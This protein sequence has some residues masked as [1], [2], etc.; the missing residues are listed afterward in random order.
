MRINLKDW[1]S[2]RSLISSA[3]EALLTRYP[4]DPAIQLVLNGMYAQQLRIDQLVNQLNVIMEQSILSR[5][6]I[7]NSNRLISEVKTFNT[8][9]GGE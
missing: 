8:R 9:I 7:D 2:S 5:G 6:A 3:L 4:N 1:E